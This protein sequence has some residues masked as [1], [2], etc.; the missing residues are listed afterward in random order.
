MPSFAE[1]HEYAHL[2]NNVGT[3]IYNAMIVPLIPF[4]IRGSLWYQGESNAGRAY[5][6]RQSFPLMINDWRKLWNDQFSF[7]WVQLSSYGPY[8]D[9]NKGS[10]WAELREAQDMTLS[11]PKTG[12]AVTTDVG[13]PKDIH[14]TNKQDVAHRLAVNAL[15]FDYGQDIV[16]SS[17]LYDHVSFDGNKAIISFKHAEGGLI[18]KDK[19]GYLKGFEIAGDDKVFYYAKAEIVGNQVVVS[20]PKVA[21]PVSVRYAW[22]DSPEDANLYNAAGFPASGFR[23]DTWPGIT[24]KSKFE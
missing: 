18:V 12:M 13:N 17:P 1:K 3:S 5:Q 2:M 14:P 22:A 9:S 10:G 23:T 7:Y 20:H 24:S 11:L 19:F 6:Y 16:Y 21:T 4:A 8:N 15:K